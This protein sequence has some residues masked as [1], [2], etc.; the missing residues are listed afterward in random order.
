MISP[1]YKLNKQNWFY[2]NLFIRKDFFLINKIV[3]KEN[4][5]QIS[6]EN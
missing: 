2:F 3:Q 1:K 4:E 5:E 6:V